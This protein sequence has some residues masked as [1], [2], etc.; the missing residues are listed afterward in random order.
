MYGLPKTVPDVE[1]LLAL[2]PEE[3]AGEILIQ[4]RGRFGKAQFHPGNL[5]NELGSNIHGNQPQYPAN[6]IDDAR[7]ALSEAWA[8]LENNGL[9]VPPLN[10]TNASAGWRVLSRQGLQFERKEDFESFLK[11]RQ[12][13]KSMLH[14]DIAERVWLSVVRGEFDTAVFQA[15]KAVEIAV[16]EAAAF[17]KGDHGVPMI[18]RAFHPETGPLRDPDA[19]PSEREALMHLFAGA[20]GSYKNPHSHRNIPLDDP[21]EAA[22]I[23]VLASHLLRLVDSRSQH[24]SMKLTQ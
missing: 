21:A 23:V 6:R 19:E 3:L 1:V 8:W 15:M 20:I 14:P 7:L 11:A 17:P 13:P 24:L 9:I 4:V 22:E 16:R 2:S 12:L 10:D 18:R 5:K